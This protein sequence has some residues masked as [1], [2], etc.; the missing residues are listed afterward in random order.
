MVSYSGDLRWDAT[1]SA[2]ME[3]AVSYPFI[4]TA[5]MDRRDL[6]RSKE[7]KTMFTL[8]GR[9]Q[10]LCGGSRREFLR[11]GGLGLAGLSLAQLMQAEALA[12][13]L[14][15]G[16]GRRAAR[17]P[18][19]V[20]YIALYGGI[21]HIDTWDPKPEAPV[22]Y[23]GEFSAIPTRLPG[24]RLC[25]LFPRQAAMMDRLALLQGVQSVEN[26]H[27]LSEVYTGLPRSAGKRPAF[28]SVVSRL[29][30]HESPLPPYVTLAGVD[31][32]QFEF[33]RPYYAGA[34]HA[35]FRP[36]EDSLESLSPVKDLSRLEDRRAL[37]EGFNKLQ[38]SLDSEATSGIDRFQAAALEMIASPAVREA[39]DLSQESPE[40]FERYGRGKYTHQAVVD[41]LYDW[42]PKPI[43]LARRLVEAGVRVV[44]LQLGS[45]DH[46]RG[47]SQHIF[48]SY[49]YS[50][51]LLDQSIAAL[52]TDL[53]ERGLID[54]VL[55]VVLG[56]FGRTPKVSYPGPGREH[57]ADAGS[58]IMAGGGLKMGQVIGETDSRGE[59]AK[60]GRITF[61]NIM[62]TIYHVLGIDPRTTLPDFTGRPQYLLDD[63]R[64]VRELLG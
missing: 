21:S 20:I 51:P 45:W 2:V 58:V 8:W 31:A 11:V 36:L 4:P 9:N 55:V 5:I 23:R 39:F 42:D 33:Q 47:E 57:W 43:V 50:L 6:G 54:D 63:H 62:A 37:L 22:E 28:G 38:R 16:P 53:E 44:T 18:K 52:V 1:P 61:Q 49:R 46:H 29:A 40:T 19:S 34:A 60:S 10:R 56:E 32:D 3:P 13:G 25:E 27:F 17:R 24:V 14:A 30:R 7:G 26:D 64:P 41:I 12:E 15:E 59:R 35:P 48:K